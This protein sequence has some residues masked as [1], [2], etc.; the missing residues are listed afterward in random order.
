[1]SYQLDEHPVVEDER[2]ELSRHLQSRDVI[3]V[4]K[5]PPLPELSSIKWWEK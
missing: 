1:M 3:R 5:T 4:Y 2:I